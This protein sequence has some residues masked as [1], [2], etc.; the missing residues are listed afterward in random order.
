MK[1][2]AQLIE[3]RKRL[4][5]DLQNIVSVGKAEK[6]KLSAVEEREIVRLRNEITGIDAQLAG[7]TTGAPEPRKAEPKAEQFNILKAI[8]SVAYG[9]SMEDSEQRHI[10]AGRKEM[11][12]A[13]V[14]ARGNIIIPR[15]EIRTVIS[16]GGS[17]S[18]I[19]VIAEQKLGL[20]DPLRDALVLVQAG[21]QY[22]TGLTGD[23]SIPKYAGTTA[24]WKGETA[25]AADGAGATSE[26]TLSA[27]RLT[28]YVD[29]SKSFLNQDGVGFN[30]MLMRDMVNAVAGKLEGTIL[31]KEA[32][33]STQPAGFFYT[34]PAVKGSASWANIIA[35]ETAV[36]TANALFE[37]CSYITNPAGRGLLKGTA[38]V[39]NAAEFLMAADGTLNG[40]RTLVTNAVASALQT[41]A[42]EYGIIFGNW[43]HL[44]IGQ[45][46]GFDL[47]V[48]PYTLAKDGQVRLVIN[49]YFDATTRHAT[50]FKTG[51]LK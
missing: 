27:K 3:K 51:S 35:L 6:R 34:A 9:T 24:L 12:S 46:G 37:N 45:W 39:A 40:Y 20:V 43:A 5:T 50:A 32:G 16:A 42:D 30:E 1:D 22:L 28:A 17:G 15:N 11:N 33:S 38:K 8:R 21:A 26:A 29:V 23:V 14:E 41:G 49:A 18:G 13:K 4:H 25:A 44:I 2:Q 31:G 19:E 48:D 47:T 7:K 36:D 10:D